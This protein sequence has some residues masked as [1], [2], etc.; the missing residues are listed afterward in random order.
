MSKFK[1]GDTIIV[2][3]Q[4]VIRGSRP[5]GYV[6]KITSI[7]DNRVEDDVIYFL[8]NGNGIYGQDVDN[9]NINNMNIIEKFTLNLKSEPEKS[10]RKAGIIN[11]DDLLTDDGQKIFLTWLLSKN[12]QEFRTEV[13]DGI[14]DEMK[15]EDKK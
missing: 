3:K 6:G 5:Y 2:K 8:D 12:K 4:G 11:G 9:N 14:L 10:F 13:V 1:I 15:E 7:D